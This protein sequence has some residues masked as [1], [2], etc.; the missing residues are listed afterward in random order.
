MKCT[1]PLFPPLPA[2]LPFF[3]DMQLAA[4]PDFQN[5]WQLP[6]VAGAIF[7]AISEDIFQG[8]Q[9]ERIRAYLAIAIG[10]GAILSGWLH[11]FFALPAIFSSQGLLGGPAFVRALEMDEP[12]GKLSGKSVRV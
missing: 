11:G 10:L 12:A 5:Q 9:D 3:T 4:I 6:L 1:S 8:R 7:L 2:F